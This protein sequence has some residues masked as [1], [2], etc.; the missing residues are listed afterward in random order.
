MSTIPL[1]VNNTTFNYPGAGEDP[2][3]GEDATAWAS[4]VTQVLNSLLGPGDLL[5]TTFN[6]ANNIS[7]A[8]EVVGLLFDTGTVRAAIIEYSLYR[9]SDST[10]S[11]AAE[12]GTMIMVYDTSASAGNKWLLVQESTG[13]AGIALTVTDSG[14]FEYT[15]TDIGSVNYSGVLKFKA[16]TLTQ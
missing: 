12:S 8:E 7:S 9:V 10:P 14:Q 2:G 11:G 5:E 4:A 3:W 15:T 16:R 13:D 1:T 6:A